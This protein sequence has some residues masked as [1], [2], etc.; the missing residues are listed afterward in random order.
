MSSGLIGITGVAGFVGGHLLDHL[1]DAGL[2]IVCVLRPSRDPSPFRRRGYEVRI[3]DL[4]RPLTCGGAFEGIDVLI[5]LSGMG[6]VAGLVPL[7]EQAGL[8]RGVFLGSTGIHT[9]LASPS[10]EAKRRGEA[11]LLRSNLAW[12]VLRPTMIYGGPGDRNMARLLNLIQRVG[13]VPVPGGGATMQQPV[14]VD[15]LVST[16]VA[17]LAR[18]HSIARAYDVG[19]P[20]AMPLRNVIEEAARSM[21]RT[22]WIV[23]LPVT[24]SARAVALVRRAGVPFPLRAEQILR[25]AETKAVEIGDAVRDL[26]HRPRPF[27]EGIRQEAV[28]LG[29]MPPD[30]CSSVR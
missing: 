18:P 26:G 29:L 15:D 2:K 24:A 23:P 1:Q 5:H 21:G 30:H 27:V 7:L 10:A 28:A 16:I 4:G 3:A 20:E 25:L 11:A 17:S 8:R 13:V 14:H 22:A 19:G 12:T 6:Q 9:R